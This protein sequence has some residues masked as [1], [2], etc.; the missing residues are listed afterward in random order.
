M[1]SAECCK[2]NIAKCYVSKG[3]AFEKG[4]GSQKNGTFYF[5][6]I[7]EFIWIVPHNVV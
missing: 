5:I 6:V 7:M 4:W 1:N 3:R 2:I